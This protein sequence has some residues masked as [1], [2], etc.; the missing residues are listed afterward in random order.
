MTAIRLFDEAKQ[1]RMTKPRSAATMMLM[2]FSDVTADA[3]AGRFFLGGSVG[4]VGSGGVAGDAFRSVPVAI[5]AATAFW[6][7]AIS[8]NW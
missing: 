4:S 5:N 1:L 7:A 3:L 6:K 8:P 2:Q